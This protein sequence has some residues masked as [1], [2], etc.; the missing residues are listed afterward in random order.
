MTLHFAS[1]IFRKTTTNNLFEDFGI[2]LVWKSH[3]GKR[4][5]GLAAHGINIAQ[6]ICRRNLP[7]G[8]WVIHNRCKKVHGLDHGHFGVQQIHPGV[9]V[10]IKTNEHV[11]IRWPRQ[12]AQN[13]IQQPWTQL[14]RSTRCLDHGREFHGGGQAAPRCNALRL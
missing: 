9:V 6:R 5:N 4:G 13:G 2:A 14:R 11:R 8:M 12:T 3:D 10:G 1:V 7:E